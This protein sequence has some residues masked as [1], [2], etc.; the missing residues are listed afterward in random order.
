MF[1]YFSDS[2]ALLSRSRSVGSVEV[3]GVGNS[4]L[5]SSSSGHQQSSLSLNDMEQL[6]EAQ[7][8]GGPSATKIPYFRAK[9]K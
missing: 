2:T 4:M 6:E 8:Q 3:T 1:F 7:L 9:N 5:Q